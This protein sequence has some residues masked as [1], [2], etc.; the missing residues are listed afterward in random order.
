MRTDGQTDMIK[1]RVAFYTSGKAPKKNGFLE[2][3][4][5]FDTAARNVKKESRLV[6]VT[7]LFHERL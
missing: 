5:T 1:L 7:L 2:Q 6:S 4:S 3:R